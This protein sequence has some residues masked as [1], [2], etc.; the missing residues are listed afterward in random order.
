MNSG[1]GTVLDVHTHQLTEFSQQNSEAGS[2]D[3]R[4][5]RKLADAHT[6]SHGKARIQTQPNSSQNLRGG[7][8][9]SPRFP[10]LSLSGPLYGLSPPACQI[11]THHHQDPVTQLPQ[12]KAQGVSRKPTSPVQSYKLYLFFFSPLTAAPP[13]T[14]LPHKYLSLTLGNMYWRVEQRNL[15]HEYIY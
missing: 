13:Q 10:Y 15:D 3:Q 7:C 12:H 14:H 2:E 11:R 4:E 8:L 9:L 5:T 6:V 1:R